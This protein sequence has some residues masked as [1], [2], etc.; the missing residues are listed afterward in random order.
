MCILAMRRK[1]VVRVTK[2]FLMHGAQLALASEMGS[3][4]DSS[5][6]K[7]VVGAWSRQK[8]CAGKKMSK[9]EEPRD[10]NTKFN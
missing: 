5:L 3:C 4:V 10:M 6:Q 9:E 7:M 8:K 1:E 2:R